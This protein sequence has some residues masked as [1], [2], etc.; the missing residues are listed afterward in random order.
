MLPAVFPILAGDSGVTG[1]IG[2]SPAR[3]YRHGDAPQTVVAPYVTWFVVSGTPEN[4]L[5]E[6][7]KVDNYTVQVDCWSD[8]DAEVEQMAAAVRDAL[9]AE[10]HMTAVGPNGRDPETKRYRIGM[11]FTFWTSR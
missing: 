3:V 11:S 4:E 6:L 5:D 9:E 2:T 7:P 1:F 8:S 10:Y